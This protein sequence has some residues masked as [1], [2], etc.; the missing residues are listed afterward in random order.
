MPTMKKSNA[1]Q[2]LEAFFKLL[3]ERQC[4]RVSKGKEYDQI[5]LAVQ[6]WWA[7]FVKGNGEQWEKAGHE[8]Q[9]HDV[10][11]VMKFFGSTLVVLGSIVQYAYV[12]GV[13]RGRKEGAKR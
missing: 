10:P 8:K 11:D 9:M 1:E 2:I 13:R 3:N 7:L 6:A 5:A 12:L 4:E